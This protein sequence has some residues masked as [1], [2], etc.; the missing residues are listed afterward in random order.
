MKMSNK[1]FRQYDSRWGSK[2]YPTKNSSFAGNGCGACA[3]THLIIETSKYAAYTPE[4]VRQYMIKYAV[5]GQGTT[6]NGIPE[7]L[8]HYGFSKVVHIGAADPMSKVWTE[9]NKGRRMGVILFSAGRG[10]SKKLMWTSGGHYVAFTDYKVKDGKHYFYTKDSGARK[11]DGWHTYEEHMRGR[12]SQMWIVERP[13][14]KKPVATASGKS[15]NEKCIDAVIAWA[16][17]YEADNSY[18]YKKWTPDPKTHQ[19]PICHPNSG[20]GWNCIG[21]V[22]AAYHH[23]GGVKSVRCSNSGLGN[24]AWFD[25]VTPDKWRERNGQNWL[26]VRR[27]KRGDVIICYKNG[28]YKHTALYIGDGMIIDATSSRG[29]KKRKY[30]EL[31]RYT[32]KIF[33]YTGKGKF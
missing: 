10:G 16:K 24:N 7:S 11:N 13:A 4:K 5:A 15:A 28:K 9:L 22:S 19:C 32:K 8:K 31:S 14:V 3:V 20:K 18:K 29:I 30:S 23:G 1:I 25:T 2:P 17:K 6:W 26:K 33:R 21:F 27:K 12:V